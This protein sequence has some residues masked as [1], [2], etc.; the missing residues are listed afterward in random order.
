MRVR[1]SSL[2]QVAIAAALAVLMS[3]L[4]LHSQVD[5]KGLARLQAEIRQLQIDELRFRQLVEQGHRGG[6][7]N[8]DALEQV[9]ARLRRG[10]ARLVEQLQAREAL[11]TLVPRAEALRA[12]QAS[13][14]PALQR[15]ERALSLRRLADLYLPTLGRRLRDRLLESSQGDPKAA[16]ALLDRLAELQLE[17]A[18]M[19]HRPADDGTRLRALVDRMSRLPGAFAAMD[20][21]T[22]VLANEFVRFASTRVK[23]ASLTQGQ[24]GVLAAEAPLQ[25]LESLD[26]A[27]RGEVARIRQTA[28]YYRVALFGLAIL[29]LSYL[30]WVFFNLQ[31]VTERLRRS[32]AELDFHKFVTDEHAIISATDVDGRIIYTNE[33]FRRLTGYSKEELHGKNHRIFKSGV[34]DQAFYREMWETI[35]RG[36]VWRGTICNRTRDGS[37]CWLETTI[38]PRLGPDGRPYEYFAIRT[39]VSEKVSAEQQVAWLARIPE[40][41]PEPVMRLDRRGRV[42]YAN[43][44]AAELLME[45]QDTDHQWLQQSWPTSVARAL[46]TGRSQEMELL[47][48][49]RYYHFYLVPVMSEDYVNIYA[50]DVTERRKA[51]LQLSHQARH[52]TLTGL[53]NRRAFEAML[54]DAIEAARFEAQ[55]SMLLYLDL[56]QFKVVNDTCG[57]V[58]GDEL[59]RQLGTRLAGQVRGNDEIARL[60]GD[61]FAV[62]LRNCPPEIGMEIAE[63]LRQ[64]VADFRFLWEDRS[65]RVG[66][67]IGVVEIREDATSR[68]EILAAADVAC[69]AAKDSGRN[70]IH[71]YRLDDGQAARRRDEMDWAARIPQALVEDRFMLMVQPVVPLQPDSGER[72][73][74]EVL[75]RMRDEDGELIPPGAFIPAAER[76]DLMPA[77]DHWVVQQVFEYLGRLREAG[78]DMQRWRFAVNLCGPSLSDAY[79]VEFIADRLRELE[80]PGGQVSFEITETAAVSNLSEAVEFIQRLKSLGCEIA[81]DDFGSGL[82]SFAYL[83]NLPVD[84]LKIDGTFVKDMLEDPIDAAMVEAINQIGHVMNIRTIAEFVE[85]DAIR[86]RLQAIGVDFGQGYGIDRP[87]SLEELV[88]AALEMRLAQGAARAARLT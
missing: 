82:S 28:G 87:R 76:Y 79:L 18:G 5:S 56:D 47:V 33:H 73:H 72:G 83:K 74:Y 42:L 69:Y 15:F 88:E 85:S 14:Q 86:R 36:E 30:A 57:H 51:E 10:H 44:A 26:G 1:G 77:I 3:Y 31:N 48:S 71:L 7:F 12:L 24:I 54:D 2:A 20:Q 4:Y 39:D 67:S 70:R 6:L 40:E 13:R 23:A 53:A 32:L 75:I 27:F 45:L 11:A 64:Q 38:V 37:L 9:N 58:A 65:F 49:G 41:N 17:L 8:Y 21:Q 84:F 66:V 19:E 16:G 80:L 50:H 61:E 43:E 29:L 60:G 46:E 68:D 62:L 55:P 78:E 34:H 35:G 22:R 63:K 59:L 25:Q 52:D 81:L